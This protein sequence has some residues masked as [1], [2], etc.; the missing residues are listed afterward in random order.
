MWWRDPSAPLLAAWHTDLTPEER[1]DWQ[2]TGAQDTSQLALSAEQQAKLVERQQTLL[3]ELA[4]I[5]AALNLIDERLE[6]RD[7]AVQHS[8][9]EE[10][11]V[12][13]Q[14]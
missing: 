1:S 7:D 8:A 11:V 2:R 9:A 4:A 10:A 5:A 12:R 14:R 3:R 13:V 6:G